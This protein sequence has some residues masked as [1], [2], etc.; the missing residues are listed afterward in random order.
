[1]GKRRFAIV[2]LALSAAS[3]VF[4]QGPTALS[5]TTIDW[6]NSATTLFLNGSGVA[7]T[8]GSATLNTDGALVQL[9]YFDLANT[10]NNFAGTWVPL[11][12]FGTAGKTTIGDSPDLTGLGDGRIG[13]TTTFHFGS[14]QHE[15][16]DPVFDL[17]SYITQSQSPISLTNPPAGQVLAI[18]FY[19]SNAG[20]AYNT[21]SADN[22]Q[23]VTPTDAGSTL[24]INVA[25]STLEWQD[26]ANAFRTSILPIPEPS[27]S[28]L[29]L[30]TALAVYGYRRAR[31]RA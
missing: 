31:R 27:T 14:N 17:G 13:F 1:M 12:G 15:V 10:S 8:Q 21:V 4:G 29:L 9:G 2:A 23:W 18:R 20:G 11:T 26:P 19:D 16:Y 30:T 28:A 25:T 24:L 3:V 7:L 5:T 6:F 22:W